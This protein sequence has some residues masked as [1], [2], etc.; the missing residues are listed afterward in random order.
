MWLGFDYI[1]NWEF[2]GWCLEL[3]KEQVYFVKS[4]ISE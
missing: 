3:S 1:L 4:G 2:K